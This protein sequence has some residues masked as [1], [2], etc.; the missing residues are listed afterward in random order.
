M[1]AP[2][3]HPWGHHNREWPAITLEMS[4]N[5][6]HEV[7]GEPSEFCY[8]CFKMLYF[9]FIVLRG[10][11]II[12]DRCL[13]CL[14]IFYAPFTRYTIRSLITPIYWCSVPSCQSER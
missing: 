12:Y 13:R 9:F 4:I 5:L 7:F 2:E 10:V 6:S 8:F 11:D 14:I 1:R 3:Y